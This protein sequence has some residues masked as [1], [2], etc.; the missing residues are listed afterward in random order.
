MS[1]TGD[2][3]ISL[4]QARELLDT[5][6]DGATWPPRAAALIARNVLERVV[7]SM[8]GSLAADVAQA[9]MRTRLIVLRALGDPRI[10][11]QAEI[12]WA[13]L[14]AACHHHAYELAP[15]AGEIGHLI[16]IVGNLTEGQHT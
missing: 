14:S 15:H 16:G 12:A 7:I 8:C 9:T 5:A 1:A 4:E 11:D 6:V 10:A 13:E 2:A 3:Q